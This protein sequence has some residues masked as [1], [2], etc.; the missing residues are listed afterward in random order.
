MEYASKKIKEYKVFVS[1]RGR[2]NK[3]TTE[4]KSK[5]CMEAKITNEVK[6]SGQE[7]YFHLKD[8]WGDYISAV[9]KRAGGI[10][11]FTV[12]ISTALDQ[13]FKTNN[14]KVDNPE[15]ETIEEDLILSK[16]NSYF[17]MDSAILDGERYCS[18]NS[19]QSKIYGINAEYESIVA[20]KVLD[21][22][23]FESIYSITINEE[24]LFIR[25]ETLDSNALNRKIKKLSNGAKVVFNGHVLIRT[26]AQLEACL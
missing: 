9:K 26:I 15:K 6:H 11:K 8:Y 7:E 20:L 10:A 14:L 21:S 1:E 19:N 17:Y 16:V 25:A 13:N 5:T 22:N 23:K 18:K 4:E 3:M 24:T 2:L 12:L